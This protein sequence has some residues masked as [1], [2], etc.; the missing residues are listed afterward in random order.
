M[1]FVSFFRAALVTCCFASAVAVAQPPHPRAG[2]LVM[3][4]HAALAEDAARGCDQRVPGSGATIMAAH[5]AWQARHGQA[6]AALTQMMI[7][8]V[9]AQAVARGEAADTTQTGQVLQTIRNA[10]RDKLR[11]SISAMAADAL[12]RFCRDYPGQ[13]DKPE[14]DFTTIYL[15]R[16]SRPAR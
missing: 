13:Y 7:E 4:D 12:E 14:M 9:T 3:L 11:S 10:S 1:R 15:M 16:S 2:L 8:E 5:A 6:H